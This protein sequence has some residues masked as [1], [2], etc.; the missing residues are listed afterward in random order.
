[1]KAKLEAAKEH[2]GEIEG[3]D[4]AEREQLQAAIEDLTTD[5]ARTE[6]A[7]TRF[8]RLMRKA[9]QTASGGLYRLVVE[10]ASEAAKKAIFG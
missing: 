3:L 1:M 2:A 5:G 9:G 10:V 4:A 6:L 7:A 8:K